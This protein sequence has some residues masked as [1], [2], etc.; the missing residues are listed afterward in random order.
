VGEKSYEKVERINRLGGKGRGVGRK[1]LSRVGLVGDIWYG[2][3]EG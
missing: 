1:S 3:K 2:G